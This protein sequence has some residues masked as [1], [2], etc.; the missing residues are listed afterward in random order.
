LGSLPGHST[1]KALGISADGQIVAGEIPGTGKLWRWKEW[2]GMSFVTYGQFGGISGD[3]SIIVGSTL[4][5]QGGFIWDA[6]QGS[7][8]LASVLSIEYGLDLDGWT[9]HTVTGI[10]DDGTAII[11]Y[12]T[13]PYGQTEAWIAHIPEPTSMMLVVA[14]LLA[15]T[16]AICKRSASAL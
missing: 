2:E 11:G 3:G 15:M 1:S 13:N 12:G 4:D 10:S 9:L 16:G 7:R 14:G 5:G 6:I 8:D